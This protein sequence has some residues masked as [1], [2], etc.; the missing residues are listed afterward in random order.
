MKL[1]K[2]MFTFLLK[3]N[4]NSVFLLKKYFINQDLNEKF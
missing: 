1:L 4:S 3:I 2:K